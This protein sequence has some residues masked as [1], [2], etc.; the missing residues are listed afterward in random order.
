MD[1]VYKGHSIEASAR[2][3]ADRRGWK[4]R[5]FVIYSVGTQEIVKNF[6]IDKIFSTREEAEQAGL[7]FAKKWIDG[8]KPDLKR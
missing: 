8:G 6:A 3:I 2:N 1:E 5:I 7:A 4:P